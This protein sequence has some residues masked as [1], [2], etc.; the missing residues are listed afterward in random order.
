[1]TQ[2]LHIFRKDVR[3]QWIP[4]LWVTGLEAIYTWHEPR[5]WNGA[6]LGAQGPLFRYLLAMLMLA[7]AF[8][9]VR[10]V[11]SESLV[12]DLQYWITRPVE[13]KP[14]L[15]SKLLFVAVFIEGPLLAAN[16]YLLLRSGHHPTLSLIGGILEN[17]LMMAVFIWLP[18]MALASVGRNIGHFALGLLGVAAVLAAASTITD[19]RGEKCYCDAEDYLSLGPAFVVCVVVLV[20]QY[21]LR[22]TLES[23]LALLAG[24]LSILAALAVMPYEPMLRAK[25]PAL[26]TSEAMPVQL[27]PFPAYSAPGGDADGVPKLTVPLKISNIPLDTFLRV[28]G[29]RLSLD[30]AGDKHWDSPWAVG[31]TLSSTDEWFSPEFELK[32]SISKRMQNGPA[33][34]Y[35]TIAAQLWRDRTPFSVTATNGLFEIPGLGSCAADRRSFSNGVFCLFAV[36]GPEMAAL[37]VDRAESTCRDVKGEKGIAYATGGDSDSG[38]FS[39]IG[40]LNFWEFR[41]LDKNVKKV[42]CSGT[43]IRV[44]RPKQE[45]NFTMRIDLRELSGGAAV[46]RL[47]F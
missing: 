6:R 28:K 23:R 29:V 47:Y 42:V 45:R 35:L 37:S 12:G 22:R 4:I 33:H 1:M 39:P 17:H 21:A 20:R 16:I 30:L 8:L 34:G 14:L 19:Y 18:L 24:G 3:Q 46:S 11:Q 44:S 15:A 32:D 25:F 36:S 2:V 9:I 41:G 7:W 10:V 5:N 43:P 27:E 38:P 13:W 40:T 31:T 26:A